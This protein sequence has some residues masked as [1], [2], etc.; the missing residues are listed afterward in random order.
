MQVLTNAH[1]DRWLKEVNFHA[2]DRVPAEKLFDQQFSAIFEAPKRLYVMVGTDSGLL[3]D[4]VRRH[5]QGEGRAFVFIEAP[6]V[7]EALSLPVSD[8]DDPPSDQIA[9]FPWDAEHPLG[10]VLARWREGYVDYNRVDLVKSL[11][12]LD[13]AELEK[14]LWAEVSAEF[15]ILLSMVATAN[16]HKVFIDRQILNAADNVAPAAS[17]EKALAGLP[18]VVIGG[19]PTLDEAIDWIREHQDRCVVAAVARVCGRLQE[20]GIEPDIVATVDPHEVSYDNAKHMLRFSERSIYIHTHNSH[21]SLIAEW[22]GEHAYLE[23]LFPWPTELNVPNI[24]SGGPTVTNTLIQ[25]LIFAGCDTLYLSGVDFCY[26]PEGQTHES[27]S[28]DSRAGSFI[29]QATQV[30]ETWSGRQARTSDN[31]YRAWQS[32]QATVEAAKEVRFVSLGRES[33]RLEGARYCPPEEIR[34]DEALDKHALVQALRQSLHRDE[35]TV[36]EHVRAVCDELSRVRRRLR[37]I[38]RLSREGA[39]ISEKLFDNY[40]RLDHYTRQVQ[41][42][43]R[44]LMQPKYED[45]LVL[46][47]NYALKAYADFM[48]PSQRED[49]ALTERQIRD[50]LLNFFR[51]V[52]ETAEDLRLSIE[53]ALQHAQMRLKEHAGSEKLS[54]LAD[55]WQEK[56]QEGRI[57]LWCRWHGD[58]KVDQGQVERLRVRFEEK[59]AR[60]F[61]QT[62]LSQVLQ[63]QAEKMNEQRR[64][65]EEGFTQREPAL[66]RQALAALPDRDDVRA[67]QLR[68]LGEGYLAELEQRWDEAI[69]HYLA[70]SYHDLR[71]QGLTRAAQIAIELQALDLAQELMAELV[72]YDERYYINLA[73]LLRLQG[74]L[75]GAVN[76]FVHYLNRR[77]ED[78]TVWSRLLEMLIEAG[79]C[80]EA[81]N[82]FAQ[83]KQALPDSDLISRFEQTLKECGA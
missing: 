81:E 45:L 75:A 57:C 31:F 26:G 59:L 62:K 78:E 3:I 37:D 55:Y 20:E 18:A 41:R 25:L 54:E 63:Q 42:I 28:L 39:R 56:N 48:D 83:M 49:E 13:G 69:A 68:H 10:R 5:W 70:L 73:D 32:L 21:S 27:R 36:A 29:H 22:C 2:F 82:L 14:A 79:E 53:Q 17:L 30:L 51:A 4:Y 74:D 43:H 77:P 7:I 6:E 12:V 24:A 19:G 60:P 23:H 47:H 71:Q 9:L 35:K 61:D 16:I 1:G 8:P 58:E 67:E 76:I 50:N 52:Y 40:D 11:G 72:R 80:D 66:I 38:Q 65:I 46:L 64:L 44:K 34:L 33:A 15:S